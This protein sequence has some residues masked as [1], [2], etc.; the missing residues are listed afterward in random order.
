MYIRVFRWNRWKNKIRRGE[1]FVQGGEDIFIFGII[2]N[3]QTFR[4]ENYGKLLRVYLYLKNRLFK[5]K[6]YLFS[7]L[8]NKNCEVKYYSII[9][10]AKLDEI[11]IKR[12]F[13][14][15]ENIFSQ[16]S[17]KKK[18]RFNSLF[19]SIKYLSLKWRIIFWKN[20]STDRIPWIFFF[21]YSKITEW[22]AYKFK[23]RVS[24]IRNSGN[25]APLSRPN[26]KDFIT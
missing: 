11:E 13:K 12:N 10:I 2:L 24:L 15:W 5:L 16:S 3:F 1:T 14:Q 7:N 21:R 6:L 8:E 26:I 4:V 20:I 23:F 9:K 22:F 25:R 18:V 17:R 19:F